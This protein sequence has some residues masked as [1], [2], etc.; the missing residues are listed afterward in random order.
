[1]RYI[2]TGVHHLYC[3]KNINSSSYYLVNASMI[4]ILEEGSLGKMRKRKA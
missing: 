2:L 4:H 3:L 1:M